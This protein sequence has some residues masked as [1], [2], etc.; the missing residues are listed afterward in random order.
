MQGLSV[1]ITVHYEDARGGEDKVPFSHTCGAKDQFCDD[2]L[3]D[4]R[5][6]EEELDPVVDADEEAWQRCKCPTRKTDA[7]PVVRVPVKAR[8]E[9][10]RPQSRRGERETTAERDTGVSDVP[11]GTIA[12]I[13]FEDADG[14]T[15][16]EQP[17]YVHYPEYGLR[18]RGALTFPAGVEYVDEYL[19]D[20]VVRQH[21]G[22]KDENLTFSIL[23][24]GP[25]A[26]R[27]P[28]GKTTT[29]ARI[30][31]DPTKEMYITVT[32]GWR[33]FTR[34]DGM[35]KSYTGDV[36]VKNV[37]FGIA[38]TICLLFLCAM[39]MR[40]GYTALPASIRGEPPVP[41]MFVLNTRAVG[42][43]C[44]S[45]VACAGTIGGLWLYVLYQIAVV[46]DRIPEVLIFGLDRFRGFRTAFLH[47]G[48]LL[49]GC[50]HSKLS[51]C[52][53]WC[54]AWCGSKQSG[55]TLERYRQKLD[56]RHKIA[57]T[58]F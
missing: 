10:A 21:E 48:A 36:V 38:M 34:P 49:R 54:G 5:F 28:I 53:P 16:I 9:R 39:I 33:K 18:Y 24:D 4:D 51:Y 26:K 17:V 29:N 15:W 22:T 27:R 12:R 8:Q 42:M 37:W 46:E 44:V 31:A 20:A 58:G 57:K 11:H 55:P 35:W 19:Y 47:L 32:Y 50:D 2:C 52:S 45:L 43:Q 30:P 14:N 6:P 40:D 25:V 7:P 3:E 23:H 41:D 1:P 56:K 13:E